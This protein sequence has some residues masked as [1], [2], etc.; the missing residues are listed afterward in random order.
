MYDITIET[1][2]TILSNFNMN[3]KL[4]THDAFP[5][6]DKFIY[7]AING[8][9]A[10]RLLL[11]SKKKVNGN[12]ELYFIRISNWKGNQS[13]IHHVTEQLRDQNDQIVAVVPSVNE[14]EIGK[15]K[16]FWISWCDN[17]LMVGRG[18]RYGNNIMLS[19][20][21]NDSIEIEEIGITG[22]EDLIWKFSQTCE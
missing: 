17:T 5:D 13:A 10:A 16:N 3:T 6:G 22:G 21:Q 12:N 8:S 18:N 2:N 19:Y 9:H 1:K 15:F 11:K 20:E 4:K 14:L 7:F